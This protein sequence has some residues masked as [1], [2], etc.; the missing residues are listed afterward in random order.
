MSIA[1][2]I[3]TGALLSLSLATVP[4][5]AAIQPLQMLHAKPKLLST[6]DSPYIHYTDLGVFDHDYT[7]QVT[8]AAGQYNPN[9]GQCTVGDPLI[10]ASGEVSTGDHYY[11]ALVGDQLAQAGTDFSCVIESYIDMQAHKK[12]S[13]QYELLPDDDHTTYVATAQWINLNYPQ[14]N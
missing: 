6:K 10:K 14:Q 5:L 13:I 7:I 1:K 8:L 2:K 4:A 3:L 9:T 12:R 11:M